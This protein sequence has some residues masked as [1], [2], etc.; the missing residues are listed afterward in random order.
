MNYWCFLVHFV[1]EIKFKSAKRFGIAV[2]QGVDY[3]EKDQI[4]G[5]LKI[6]KNYFR[7]NLIFCCTAFGGIISG[8]SN[9][10]SSRLRMRVFYLLCCNLKENKKTILEENTVNS[11]EKNMRNQY[12]FSF[13]FFV[14]FLWFFLVCLFCCFFVCFL[15]CFFV[16]FC[17][18]FWGFLP[19]I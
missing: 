19:K 9:N 4:K 2:S 12:L 11:K 8:R 14:L 13:V 7:G 10:P 5:L 1:F 3:R 15:F 17:L 6:K 16:C 18:F